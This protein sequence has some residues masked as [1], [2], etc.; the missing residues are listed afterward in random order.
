MTLV[1][2]IAAIVAALVVALVYVWVTAVRAVPAIK[3]KK[4]ASRRRAR[5]TRPGGAP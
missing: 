2:R 4:A 3:R 5:D 1:R